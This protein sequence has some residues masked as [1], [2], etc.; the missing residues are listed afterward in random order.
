MLGK[1]IL[2]KIRAYIKQ[3][4]SGEVPAFTAFVL[5]LSELS[6]GT[7]R[8]VLYVTESSV[9]S[10]PNQLIWSALVALANHNRGK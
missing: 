2:D 7:L 3:K 1:E 6:Q 5:P 9:I 8:Y 4:F 10:H